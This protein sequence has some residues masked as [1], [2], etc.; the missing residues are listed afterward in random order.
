MLA[1]TNSLWTKASQQKAPPRDITLEHGSKV[2]GT[3]ETLGLP[4]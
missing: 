1:L 4:C 3:Q 2:P